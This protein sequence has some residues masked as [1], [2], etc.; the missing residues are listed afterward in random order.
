MSNVYIAIVSHGHYDYIEKNKELLKI[1]ELN[2]VQVIIKDNIK[3]IKLEKYIK[4]HNLGYI[5]TDE[6]L[7]FGENNNFI[8]NY[9]KQKLNAKNEDWFIIFN[10]DVVI[11][12]DEFKKLIV[13]L[14]TQDGTFFAPNLFKNDEMIESEN[15]VRYFPK[16]INLFNPFLMKP[17]NLPYNK[18]ILNEGDIVEWA[19]G[20]FLCIKYSAFEL[21][22]GFNEKYF[23]YYEDVDLCYRLNKANISLR[24]LKEVNAVHKGE[25]KNRSIFSKHFLWYLNSLI[26]FLFTKR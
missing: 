15:S 21:V 19:S 5:T 10:P 4:D 14:T 23:M 3:D 24:F 12:L 16:L 9:S 26:R 22:N 11:T 2:N 25:Y 20:A 18:N 7:G 1:A 13:S 17:I 8:F 6:P